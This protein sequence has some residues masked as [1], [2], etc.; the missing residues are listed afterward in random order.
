MLIST[1]FLLYFSHTETLECA[2][3]PCLNGGK[4]VEGPMMYNCECK[5]GFTGANCQFEI[6]E[7]ASM[8]CP[9]GMECI[10]KVATF[11]CVCPRGRTGKNCEGKRILF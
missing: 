1:I 10:D 2:V 11:Q 4:C 6:D 7:C 5:A 3:K 8:P 9:R